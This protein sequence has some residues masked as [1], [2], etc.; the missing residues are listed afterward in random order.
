MKRVQQTDSDPEMFLVT[1]IG[2]HTCTTSIDAF[3]SPGDQC[4]LKFGSDSWNEGAQK[5]PL[6]QETATSNQGPVSSPNCQIPN[7]TMRNAVPQD[8]EINVTLTS[9]A[10]SDM[11]LMVDNFFASDVGL[12]YYDEN[13]PFMQTS[14]GNAC[15]EMI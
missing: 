10:P 1:N 6:T 7:L 4:F 2:K 5:W 12:F 3:S 15:P 13:V 14:S 8:A 9:P 11:D